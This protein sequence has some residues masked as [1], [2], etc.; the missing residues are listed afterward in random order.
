MKISLTV[1]VLGKDT[2]EAYASAQLLALLDL[3]GKWA[4]YN[5]EAALFA[6]ERGEREAQLHLLTSKVS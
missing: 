1:S 2:K 6:L 3:F 5:C 4:Q